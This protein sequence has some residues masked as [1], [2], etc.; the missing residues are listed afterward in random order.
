MRDLV[1]LAAHLG[2]EVDA[3]AVREPQRL[4]EHVSDRRRHA[5]IG[6]DPVG[7]PLPR[8]LEEPEHGARL[9]RE[10]HG[11]DARA[12][13]PSPLGPECGDPPLQSLQVH[14]LGPPSSQRSG[15]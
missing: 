6:N 3:E 1:E 12:V 14:R 15:E 7:R 10:R 2:L 11:E 9:A 4:Q 13:I 8:P 5:R